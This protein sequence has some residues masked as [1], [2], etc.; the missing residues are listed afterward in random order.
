MQKS[1]ETYKFQDFLRPHSSHSLI[2]YIIA[3]VKVLSSIPVNKL[4]KNVKNLFGA[5][6]PV[7]LHSIFHV[8]IRV[9][10]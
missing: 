3:Y 2:S 5:V 8:G 7:Q 1:P 9:A 10:M 6:A 4:S